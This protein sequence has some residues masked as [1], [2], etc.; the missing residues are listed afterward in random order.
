MF[1]DI[2][3]L[4]EHNSVVLPLKEIDVINIRHVLR[5]LLIKSCMAHLSAIDGGFGAFFCVVDYFF[6]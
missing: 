2:V 6:P 1:N 5:T 4:I 3:P